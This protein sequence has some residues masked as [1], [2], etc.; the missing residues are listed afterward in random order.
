MSLLERDRLALF[1][2]VQSGAVRLV[3]AAKL[4]E[5]SYRQAKRLWA[6]YRRW[7]DAGL[8]HGL[9]GRPGNALGR[10]QA[11]REAALRAYRQRYA[12]FG[13]TLAA[14]QMARREGLGV[15]HE[16]LRRWLIA[17][18]LWRPRR[19]PRRR[20]RRWRARKEHAGELVQ[21][22]GSEHDWLEGRGPR[23]TLMVMVDDATGWTYAEFHE[24]ETTRAAMLTLRSYARARGLPRAL[25]LDKDSAYRVNGRAADEAEHRGSGRPRT[26]FGQAAAALGVELIFAHSP[27][28]KGRV[29]RTHGTFQDRL[30]KLLRL[31]GIQD[32]AR[33]N[34]YL[35]QVYL[36]DHNARFGLAAAAPADLHRPV[37][38]SLLREALCLRESRAVGNDYCLSYQGQWLQ[39]L[40]TDVNLGLRGRRVEILEPLE[41]HLEVRCAGRRLEHRLLPERPA[42]RRAPRVLPPARGVGPE[43]WKP[44][45]GHPWRRLALGTS[46]SARARGARPPCAA[47]AQSEGTV[48]LSR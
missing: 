8:V 7:G 44:P 26:Q 37:E 23:C 24:A 4:L 39:L 25:Y 35:R 30:A 6:R 13:P 11:R 21:L 48:L 19:E 9:R 2:Q 15:D 12:G 10:S 45:A 36:P 16:T 18:R 42:A 22:D 29:E 31:E 32:L 38:E 46:G 27:Q 20:H 33:A 28:A 1:R 43:P 34:A 5:L 47:R 3:E 40:G 41:G 17:A 14:E